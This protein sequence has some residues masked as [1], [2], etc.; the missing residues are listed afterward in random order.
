MKSLTQLLVLLVTLFVGLQ[1][2]LVSAAEPSAEQIADGF[3]KA[4]VAAYWRGNSR[5]QDGPNSIDVNFTLQP[6]AGRLGITQMRIGD[7]EVPI[8]VNFPLWEFPSFGRVVRNFNLNIDGYNAAGQVIRRGNFSKEEL[9][10]GEEIEITLDLE[11]TYVSIP[12]EFSDGHTADNTKIETDDGNHEGYYDSRT[13]SFVISYDPLQP[14]RGFNI[15]DK[16]DNHLIKNIPIEDVSSGGNG[17]QNGFSLN[18]QI[19]GG[20]LETQLGEDNSSVSFSSLSLDQVVSRFGQEC[21]AKIVLV[22]SDD[23][24]KYLQVQAYGVRRGSRV[25]AYGLDT[26]GVMVFLGHR[27]AVND[28]GHTLSVNNM[29]GYRTYKIVLVGNLLD[30][31]GGANINLY[32]TDY[33]WVTIPEEPSTGS[34]GGGSSSSINE[35]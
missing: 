35:I 22:H 8:D 34:G 32:Q 24:E 7:R 10:P 16:R 27:T 19:R 11:R 28:F 5:F 9:N 29:R 33:Q 18:L 3:A 23:T 2:N 31:I 13:E 4:G 20:T 14:P 21:A 17:I 1:L 25:E 30:P 12:Y 26:N 6:K 15:I